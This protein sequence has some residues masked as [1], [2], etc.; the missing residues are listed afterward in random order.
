MDWAFGTNCLLLTCPTKPS[1]SAW[2]NLHSKHRTCATSLLLRAVGWAIMLLG[3]SSKAVVY[4]DHHLFDCLFVLTIISRA[5]VFAFLVKPI[6]GFLKSTLPQHG[7]TGFSNLFVG[8]RFEKIKT[9][10]QWI[11]VWLHSLKGFSM[12][13]WMSLFWAMSPHVSLGP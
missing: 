6:C 3:L 2:Q 7:R 8:K 13:I 12:W 1:S 11:M 9:C 10:C 5:G 4:S